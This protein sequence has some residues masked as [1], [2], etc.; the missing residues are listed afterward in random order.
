M[1]VHRDPRCGRGRMVRSMEL[2]VVSA[3]IHENCRSPSTATAC[4]KLWRCASCTNC[5][6]ILSVSGYSCSD[7]YPSY[8]S[9][10]GIYIAQNA[11]RWFILFRYQ[12]SVPTVLSISRSADVTT[13][14]T[15]QKRKVVPTDLK[16]LFTKRHTTEYSRYKSRLFR[17]RFILAPFFLFDTR[18]I[19]RNIEKSITKTKF[20][21]SYNHARN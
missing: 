12:A 9:R 4:T 13:G 19:F 20:Y 7:R 21:K 16:E 2:V 3:A 15:D 5:F 10:P 1:L 11:R 8:T 6:S 14:R 18:K 17:R